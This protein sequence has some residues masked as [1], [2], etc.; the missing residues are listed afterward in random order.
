MSTVTRPVRRET[1]E[2]VREAGKYRAVVV[3]LTPHGLYLKAKGLHGQGYLLPLGHAYQYAMR[4][5]VDR[6][7]AEKKAAKKKAREL[8]GE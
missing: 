2:T 4:L 7:K 1:S 6:R 5:E 3:T 8:Q